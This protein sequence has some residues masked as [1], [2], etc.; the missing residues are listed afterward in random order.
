MNG[1][2]LQSFGPGWRVE[3]RPL[4]VQLTDFEN[5]AYA[6]LVVLLSRCLLTLSHRF[7]LYMPM[8]YVEENMRRAQRAD[9]VRSQKFW[10]R[11]NAI[12]SAALDSD[13]YR[14]EQAYRIPDRA[15]VEVEELTLDE[16]FNGKVSN[17]TSSGREDG[18]LL[19][20][21]GEYLQS[22]GCGCVE[23]GSLLSAVSNYSAA[24]PSSTVFDGLAPYLNLISDR[25]AG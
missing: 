17:S 7:N 2:E 5:A 16:I 8:S 11:K 4:E 1:P 13:R 15:D 3:F 14:L 22:I 23:D 12:R 10:I 6:I 21:V 25:A 24:E 19:G 20:L 9:A 18:G